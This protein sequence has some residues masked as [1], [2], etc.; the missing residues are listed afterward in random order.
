MQILCPV[1]NRP[2]GVNIFTSGGLKATR[3]VSAPSQV[4]FRAE[5]M[6]IA[7]PKRETHG[8]R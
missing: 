7:V 8:S 1:S 6:L 4:S 3:D 5:V 2:D